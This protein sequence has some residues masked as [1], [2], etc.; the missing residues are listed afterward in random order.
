MTREEVSAVL[1]QR[2]DA[3]ARRDWTAMG[4][5]YSETAKVD[6]PLAGNVSGR[7]AIVRASEA[8][9][10]A[11]PDA[12]VTEEPPAIDGDRASIVAEVVGTH[13]GEILGLAPTGRP[14]RIPMAF[15]LVLQEGKIVSE[16]RIYDFTGLLV[17]IGVL[18]AKPVG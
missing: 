11:F 5:L 2:R 16:R 10:N 7:D 1:D 4:D 9:F 12:K 6:S 14:F 8:F 15:I 3:W 17:Q 13:V 18:K